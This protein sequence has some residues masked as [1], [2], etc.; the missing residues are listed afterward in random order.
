MLPI[1]CWFAE[2]FLAGVPFLLDAPFRRCIPDI[3]IPGMLIPGILLM[4]CFSAVC[5]LRV[6]FLFLRD[7]AFELDLGF[8]LLIPGMLDMSCC[9]RTGTLTKNKQAENS[10]AHTLTRNAK[11]NVLTLFMITL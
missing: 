9:A 2:F 6:T 11:L 3:F 5:F 4:S 1:G 10:S 7:I 8:G